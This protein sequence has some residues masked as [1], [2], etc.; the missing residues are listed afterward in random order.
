[1]GIAKKLDGF[2]AY[3]EK[4][5]R[6]WNVPGVGVGIVA[7]DRLVFAKGYGCRD[8]GKKLPITKNTLFQIGS[9]TKL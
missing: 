2:D 5:L 3:M 7:K 4:I 9:N 6:D 8:Y 1:M